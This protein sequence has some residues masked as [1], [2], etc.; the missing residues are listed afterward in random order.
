MAG[1]KATCYRLGGDEFSMLIDNSTD[2]HHITH[3]VQT[4]LDNMATPFI[5]NK[6]KFVL[7]ASLGIAFYPEDGKNP[8]ELLKNAD[9]AM[10]IA[11]NAGGN[12]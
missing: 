9:T 4:I 7:G 3:F 5:I 1:T 2:I 8:Q 11:K 12:K 6:Q 10:Y